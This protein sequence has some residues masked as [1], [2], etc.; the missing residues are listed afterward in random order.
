MTF[1]QQA[2]GDL[3]TLNLADSS[4]DTTAGNLSVQSG[5]AVSTGDIKIATL[6]SQATGTITIDGT[7]SL[8]EQ[9][10]VGATLSVGSASGNGI[11]LRSMS[12]TMVRFTTGTGTTIDQRHRHGQRR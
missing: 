8:L 1:R 9:T 5:A 4:S 2:T 3:G 7:N 6:T 11:G 12:K 10:L